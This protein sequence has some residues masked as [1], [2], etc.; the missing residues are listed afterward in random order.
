LTRHNGTLIGGPILEHAPVP[1]PPFPALNVTFPP[2]TGL[3]ISVEPGQT[4]TLAPGSYRTVSVKSR[5]TL[6]L[7]SSTGSYFFERLNLE[8]QA[9]VKV[10]GNPA[11]FIK[12]GFIHRGRFIT[13][14]GSPASVTI[15]Y[16]GTEAVFL[17]APFGGSLLAPKATVT[18]R[19]VY[20]GELYAKNVEVSPDIAFLCKPGGAP[21]RVLGAHWEEGA[22]DGTDA[23]GGEGCGCGTA[24]P[25]RAATMASVGALLGLS[26]LLGL[27]RRGR[28]HRHRRPGVPA[29]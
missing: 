5:G 12:L 23:A 8:P 14:S 1:L 21:V 22:G 25:G 15:G 7:S 10:N 17:E 9:D 28:R 3:P 26:A 16:N 18:V 4:R 6:V 11:L 27:V 29:G 2:P 13:S 24:L 19:A 20:T